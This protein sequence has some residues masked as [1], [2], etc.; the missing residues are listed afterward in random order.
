MDQSRRVRPSLC[1]RSRACDDSVSLTSLVLRTEKRLLPKMIPLRPFGLSDFFAPIAYHLNQ[2]ITG[3]RGRSSFWASA[4][5]WA[6]MQL[7]GDPWT[8]WRRATRVKH[9]QAA[10][11]HGQV[12]VNS[13]LRDWINGQIRGLSHCVNVGRFLESVGQRYGYFLFFFFR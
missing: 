2:P 10:L 7:K 4:K 8:P 1:A 9:E 6:Q 13:I 12:T 3:T 11:R 5:G